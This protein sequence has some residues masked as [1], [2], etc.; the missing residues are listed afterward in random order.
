MLI[1]TGSSQGIEL[2]AKIFLN[3]G[4]TVLTETPTFLGALQTF[5]TYRG[6]P[7]GVASDENGM[8]LE[9]LER[10]LAQT[11]AKLIYTI[12]T[13]QNPSGRTLPAERRERMVEIA[14]KYGAIILEDDPYCDLRY[15]GVDPPKIKSF[16]TDG[17]TVVY[18][19]SFSK[20]IS[21]G[22]RVGYAIGSP[23]ILAKMIVAKQGA[24]TH[25]SNLSQAI[26]AEY[27]KADK[28]KGHIAQC[29]AFYSVQRDAMVEA[30]KKYFPASARFER[31]Q[32]GIFLWTALPEGSDVDALFRAAVEHNV[33]FVP[34]KHF[35]PDLSGT[36]TLRLN[37]S[38]TDP[39][40]IETGMKTLGE[41]IAQ[42]N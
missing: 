4:D 35:Y 30:A 12:P 24:D 17:D 25:T 11:G 28:L 23:A 33:A 19:G 42:M 16:D 8:V 18:L 40:T 32:G 36:N 34:G 31:P 22:L 41:L 27:M 13:F 37:Y 10:K 15:E 5:R 21:P 20:I 6:V 9:D 2:S 26:V 39:E 29:C 38:M 3:D 1:L 7:V 14:K